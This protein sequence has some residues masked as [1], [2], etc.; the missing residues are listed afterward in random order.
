[1]VTP[2]PERSTTDPTCCLD[3]ELG[4]RVEPYGGACLAAAMSCEEEAICTEMIKI[5]VEVRRLRQ[6][7]ADLEMD[8][9]PELFSKLAAERAPGERLALLDQIERHEEWKAL[10]RRLGE[11]RETFG[12][13][14]RD[15][16]A[17]NRRKM[18]MLGYSV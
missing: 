12:A 7:M 9:E 5:K 13:L 8:L 4:A 1:M 14:Q 16:D 6:R 10:G 3:A 15:R 11:L 18:Q 2:G 17:A